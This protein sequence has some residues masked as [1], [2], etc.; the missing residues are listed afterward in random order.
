MYGDGNSARL[1]KD[2]MSTVVQVT[3][4]LKESTGIDLG[5]IL[6]GFAGAKM[7]DENRG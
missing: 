6:A 4:G 5:S 2:V 1:M 7:A 3:D